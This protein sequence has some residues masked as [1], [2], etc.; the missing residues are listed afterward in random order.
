LQEGDFDFPV[1]YGYAAVGEVLSGP[2][3]LEGRL[4]FCLHPHQTAFLAPRALA[5]PLPEGLPPA[6]AIL[7]ANMETALNALWDAAPEPGESVAVVGAGV[8]GCLVACLLKE[9][10]ADVVLV[11]RDP[12]KGEVARAL[13][14]AFA[15]PDRLTGSFPL[16]IHA[17]GNPEGLRSCLSRAAP[18]GRIVEMSWFGDADVPLPLGEAFHSRR[19]TLR[20]SQVGALSPNAP[21][22]TTGARMAL[23]LESLKDAR[24]DALI[25]SEGP[26]ARL[27]QDYP[28]LMQA[29][30]GVLCHRVIYPEL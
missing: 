16:Q 8:V 5:T 13:E 3:A 15:A 21:V 2:A 12:A 26:F 22:E 9:A 29:D 28:R 27:P 10:H 23:A 17:S 18:E 25:N 6:R 20:S 11:D 24:F 30:S 4:V 14:V 7:G 1:K 19:L